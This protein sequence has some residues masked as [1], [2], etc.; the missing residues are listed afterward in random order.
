MEIC[1]NVHFY[2]LLQKQSLCSVSY[3]RGGASFTSDDIFWQMQ[4]METV[5]MF[6]G[7]GTSA[8]SFTQLQAK[9]GVMHV[10]NCVVNGIVGRPAYWPS[11]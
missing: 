4:M 11:L 2:F 7:L 9:K 3:L 8:N 1:T 5:M 10:K 6:L